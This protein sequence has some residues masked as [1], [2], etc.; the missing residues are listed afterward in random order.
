[1]LQA[2]AS[3]ALIVQYILG[4]DLLTQVLDTE[5][6]LE[7]TAAVSVV[8]LGVAVGIGRLV[9]TAVP[10][11]SVL[12]AEI[13][14]KEINDRVLAVASSVELQE[15]ERPEFHDHL[16]RVVEHAVHR[17]YEVVVVLVSLAQAVL[18]GG[19][20]IAAVAV[21]DPAL[22]LI[23]ILAYV[24][25][26]VALRRGNRDV[27]RFT[28]EIAD[29]DR[30]RAYL[31]EALTDPRIAPEVRAFAVGPS[32]RQRYRS[33][34]DRRLAERRRVT[35][36]RFRRSLVAGAASAVVAGALLAV[37]LRFEAV[38]RLD[39][40][41]AIIGLVA[42]VHV[43]AQAR[44]A[45]GGLATL[46]E[47]AP[48]LADIHSF[49]ASAGQLAPA[50][51]LPRLE[52]LRLEGVSFGYPSRDELVLDHVDLELRP[53]MLVA[54]VGENGAGKTTLA[55]LLGGLYEPTAGRITWNGDDV[56]ALGAA[57]LRASSAVL[58]QDFAHY[59]LSVLTNVAP[60]ASGTT[61]TDKAAIRRSLERATADTVVDKLPD[62]LDTVLGVAFRSGTEVSGGQWQR[63]A[64]ARAL[65][66][67]ADRD[68]LIV[69]EPTAMVDAASAEAILVQL[70]LHANKRVVLV[71][72]HHPPAEDDVDLIVRLRNH[73]SGAHHV[74]PHHVGEAPRDHHRGEL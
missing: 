36:G 3:V 15:F 35:R 43:G 19:A 24:P 44:S 5:G 74:Q 73:H 71:I 13:V 37:I 1:M 47:S 58:F 21:I 23:G 48:Y 59:Q 22:V 31:A 6:S 16:Y 27:Y 18:F 34:Y 12:V 26:W 70:R 20:I 38:G 64:L 51:P 67:A 33:L 56:A 7:S 8:V 4:R 50:E 63:L 60:T 2:L 17:P 41:D 61:P 54:V 29:I 11:R 9:G 68:L 69:D 46:D 25:L 53:G 39:F 49:V 65:Y 14:D 45:Y 57:R 66:R 30:E 55:K 40:A 72:T 32:F 42:L 52:V 10:D 28:G 62:G